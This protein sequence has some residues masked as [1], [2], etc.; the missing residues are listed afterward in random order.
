MVQVNTNTP[1]SSEALLK[2][3]SDIRENSDFTSLSGLQE[4]IAMLAVYDPAD[5][6]EAE[7]LKSLLRVWANPEKFRPVHNGTWSEYCLNELIDLISVMDEKDLENYVGSDIQG[8]IFDLFQNHFANGTMT[9]TAYEARC[10]ISD[11]MDEINV[12]DFVDDF[13]DGLNLHPY[14]D[15]AEITLVNLVYNYCLWKLSELGVDENT[16]TQS[17]IKEIKALYQKSYSYIKNT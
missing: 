5:S 16:T 15:K 1:I 14:D 6:P 11:F 3:V 4:T 13:M 12:D 8:L 2:V 10:V 17:L 9:S 7:A